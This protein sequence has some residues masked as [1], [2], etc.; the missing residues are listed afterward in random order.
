[1]IGGHSHGFNTGS[2]GVV[3]LGD[4]TSTPVPSAVT[5]AVSNL[6]AWKLALHSAYPGSSVSY[7]TAS[8]SAKFAPGSTVTLPRIIGH[9]DVQSTSCPGSR[10]YALLPAIRTRVAQLWPGH[11]AH[12]VGRDTAGRQSVGGAVL[13]NSPSGSGGQTVSYGQPGDELLVGD[14]NGDGIDT[15][16]VRRG[17][18][19]LLT[20]RPAGGEPTITFSYGV[21]SD[22]ILVGDWNGDGIDTVGVRR[23][24]WF[25]LRDSNSSGGA[26]R[27]FAYGT[28]SDVPVVG[29]WDGNV[30]DTPGVRRGAWFHLRNSNSSGGANVSFAYGVSSDV[31]IVGDWDGNG[32]DSL[33]VVRLGTFHVRN[34][35]SS[36]PADS[37]YAFGSPLSPPVAGD[38]D[39]H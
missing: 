16:G 26:D 34:S 3:V 29:D 32:F 9:R 28:S 21:A 10:L 8:G 39:G 15:L 35:T 17:A 2:V 27:S 38:W 22:Q 4:F 13:T 14:W 5:S 19:V 25:Y 24:A 11:R 20:D 31:P 18:Q 30:T 23:G 36:G 7:T 1:V 37:S 33:G 12:T 6:L